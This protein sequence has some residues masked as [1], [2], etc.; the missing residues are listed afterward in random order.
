VRNNG[1]SLLQHIQGILNLYSVKDVQLICFDFGI[2]FDVTNEMT[3]KD[4]VAQAA[5]RFNVLAY[6]EN[7]V[8]GL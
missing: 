5:H 7:A 3:K 8:V 1:L 4:V 2:D 6:A